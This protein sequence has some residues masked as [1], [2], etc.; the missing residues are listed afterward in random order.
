[1]TRTMV[2]RGNDQSRQSWRTTGVPW[3]QWWSWVAAVVHRGKEPPGD[4]THP[5]ERLRDLLV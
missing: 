5:E 4:G 3:K 1:V 2:P